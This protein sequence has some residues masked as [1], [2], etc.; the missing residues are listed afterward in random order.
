MEADE[1]PISDTGGFWIRA[2]PFQDVPNSCH[3]PISL[4]RLRCWLFPLVLRQLWIDWSTFVGKVCPGSPGPIAAK[5]SDPII[6]TI[7]PFSSMVTSI[8]TNP[9]S[10][11]IRKVSYL[12]N[13]RSYSLNQFISPKTWLYG[14]HYGYAGPSVLSI[15]RG[16]L[17]LHMLWNPVIISLHTWELDAAKK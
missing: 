7:I 8:P 17:S 6:R 5:D 4:L 9:V 2:M 12:V 13:G 3:H 16:T 14:T 1:G 15:A 11:A 10:C